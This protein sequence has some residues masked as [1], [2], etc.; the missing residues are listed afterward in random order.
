MSDAIDT[1]TKSNMALV[2]QHDRD[3]YL[4][5]LFFPEKHRADIFALYAFNAEIT[6]IKQAIREPMMGEIRLQW[7]REVISGERQGEAQS[8]PV[9]SQLLRIIEQYHLP[10]QLFENYCEARV[11]DFYNDP[12]PDVTA[13]E[14]YAGETSS[15]LFQLAATIANNGMDGRTSDCAGHA[16]VAWTITQI[17]RTMPRHRARQQCYVPADM[18][19]EA[20]V[21]SED[22]Q[23]GTQNAAA[24]ILI[25]DLVALARM[26]LDKCRVAMR[27][28]PES[29]RVAFL[30]ISLISP[31]LDQYEK[32][33]A[34]TLIEPIDIAQ[35]RKQIILWRTARRGHF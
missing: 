29:S 25:G 2:R 5:T 12:M 8:H 35:W 4:A 21:S 20:G 11:F 1:T 28:I 22:W 31:M 33:G 10:R 34:R 9:A 13:L 15:I 6:H 16:G 23:A 17:L 18:M 3:I 32:A 24:K 26:H 7:W 19:L 14:A 30:P 27:K